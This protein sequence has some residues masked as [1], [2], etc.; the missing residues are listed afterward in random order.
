[1]NKHALATHL[2]KHTESLTRPAERW[3]SHQE[4]ILHR[5]KA[6]KMQGKFAV[7]SLSQRSTTRNHKQVRPIAHSATTPSSAI[8]P[9]S[10]ANVRRQG[11]L[12]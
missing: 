9:S 10:K 6:A 12:R 4:F 1:M 8:T 3:V 11:K 5:P 7:I 2:G